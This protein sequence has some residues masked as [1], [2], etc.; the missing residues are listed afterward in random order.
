MLEKKINIEV[1][2]ISKTKTH[3][4][5][6]I[7]DNSISVIKAIYISNI[8]DDLDNDEYFD[9]NNVIIGVYGKK[10]DHNTYKL[11]NFDRIEIYRKLDKSPNQKRLERL[12]NAK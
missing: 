1:C 4:V 3:L 10:I 8:I 5:S 9:I 6:I 7:V 11:K 2:Y 12:K